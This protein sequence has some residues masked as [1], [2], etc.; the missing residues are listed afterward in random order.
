MKTVQKHEKGVCIQGI[1]N[2]PECLEV[3]GGGE[4][5]MVTSEVGEAGARI[6]KGLVRYPRCLD[7][8]CTS[9]EP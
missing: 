8:T 4:G 3:L 5:Q 2:G 7:F 1:G 9:E 6:R